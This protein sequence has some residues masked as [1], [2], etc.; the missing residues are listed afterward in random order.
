MTFDSGGGRPD[1]AKT[2]KRILLY[3]LGL[4]GGATLLTWIHYRHA[5]HRTST[6]LYIGIIAVVFTGVGIWVGRKA[7]MPAPKPD[8]GLN[9][10]AREALGISDREYEVLELLAQGADQQG[11][12]ETLVRVTQHD[13]DPPR[14]TVREA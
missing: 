11:D 3:G 12:R 10:K 7:L 6:E 5:I 2:V 13:Q 9:D 14:A 8:D 4:A 1:P